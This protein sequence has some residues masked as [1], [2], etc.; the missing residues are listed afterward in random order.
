MIY[1]AISQLWNDK[2][3]IDVVTVSDQLSKNGNL[4]SV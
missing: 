2:K 3:T 4:E 1:D